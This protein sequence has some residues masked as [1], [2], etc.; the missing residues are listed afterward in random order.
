MRLAATP[1]APLLKRPEC[2][3]AVSAA[4]VVYCCVQAAD[5]AKRAQLLGLRS[6]IATEHSRDTQQSTPAPR[7]V[8]AA[9]SG[10]RPGSHASSRQQS[11]GGSSG[12][13]EDDDDDAD[14]DDIGS[15]GDA[16]S[17]SQ[18]LAGEA[19]QS[20]VQPQLLTP[21]E[22]LPGMLAIIK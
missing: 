7:P 10:S 1:R 19:S 20:E 14:G 4:A 12:D 9:V 17:C 18:G 21:P 11:Q 8:A 5:G 16:D 15:D 3:A 13:D 6:Q 22:D 2:A